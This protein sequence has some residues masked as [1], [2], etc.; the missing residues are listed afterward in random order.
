MHGYKFDIYV[1][2]YVYMYVYMITISYGDYQY[3]VTNVYHVTARI[4]VE[5]AQFQQIFCYFSDQKF[6]FYIMSSLLLCLQIS[7]QR[8][9]AF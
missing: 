5:I 1:Y 3:G 8:E 4:L 9:D 2:L 7:S 6:F